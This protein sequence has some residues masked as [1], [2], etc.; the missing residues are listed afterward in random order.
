MNCKELLQLA[1]QRIKEVNSI[2][3]LVDS[4][5]S[6]EQIIEEVN[7]DQNDIYIDG[8]SDYAN[9]SEAIGK[10]LNT[11]LKIVVS[12]TLD[13]FRMDKATEL[14]KIMG[15]WKPAVT[16][17]D[18]EQA[19]QEMEQSS[20]KLSDP[21]KESVEQSDNSLDKYPAKKKAKKSPYPDNMTVE[22]VRKMYVYQGMT[23]KQVAEN[24]GLKPSQVNAFISKNGLHRTSYDKAGKKESAEKVKPEIPPLRAQNDAEKCRICGKE[25]QFSSKMTRE[26]WPYK[27]RRKQDGKEQMVYGCDRDH[28]YAGKIKDA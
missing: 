8:L 12:N 20:K 10:E 18:F 4:I 16:N 21:V 22:L 15:V 17:K 14:K 3:T 1:E 23:L 6:L 27:Y 5:T 26:M 24:F 9:I 13:V 2:K 25:I 7:K 11:R 19:V 28:F